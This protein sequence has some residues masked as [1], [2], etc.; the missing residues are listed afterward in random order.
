M[1]DNHIVLL[2]RDK[3]WDW[4]QATREYSMAFEVSVTPYPENAGKHANGELTVTV[5]GAKHGYPQQGSIRDYFAANFSKT[6][7]DVIEVSTPDELMNILQSRID[8]RD[9]FGEVPVIAPTSMEDGEFRLIWPSDYYTVNQ[10]FGVNPEIYAQWGLP[11]HEGLDIRALYNS[12]VYACAAGKVYMALDIP[13]NH[14]YGRHVRIQHPEGYRTV[15]AHMKRLDVKLGED[16]EAR[17]V[18]GLADSTGNSSGSQLHLTLKKDGATESG[19]CNYPN[20]QIDPTPFM[21]LPDAEGGFET[22]PIK[23]PWPLTKCLVGLN[24]RMD[25]L[26]EEHDYQVIKVTNVEA[27]K[28][29][30]DIGETAISKLRE[31]NSSLFIMARL[32][33]PLGQRKAEP[34]DWVERIMPDVTRLVDKGV[35]Y[36]EVHQSPNLQSEGW[37]Y[38][39]YSGADFARWWL[40][41]VNMLNERFPGAKYGFPGL[42]PGGQVEGQRMDAEAFLEGA[43]PALA[44]ADW[45]GV[46]CFWSTLQ[47]M[48]SDSHGMYYRYYRKRFPYHLLFITE[49]GNVSDQ[50]DLQAKGKE[51][52]MY[53]EHL[54]KEAGIGASFADILYSPSGYNTMQWRME[55]GGLTQIPIEV[56][57]REFEI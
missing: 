26:F 12:N 14:P 19:E 16:V 36:F 32:Y 35:D 33:N 52:V 38:S 4:V 40:D 17:Q 49:F 8:G 56:S 1:K 6:Q 29:G 7:L 10:G 27:I 2:P 9:R 18:I 31:I 25:G 41:A 22:A 43:E 3:Y 46:N 51:C 11:G 20:D 28:V 21:L 50:V 37:G 5:V 23:Y 44:S 34:E 57:K 45:V 13:D 30:L 24:T 53:Y 48:N 15:Y 39:W 54:R 42:S 47:E 55:D